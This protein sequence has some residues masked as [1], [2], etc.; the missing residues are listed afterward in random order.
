MA[1]DLFD[2][3]FM[4]QATEQLKDATTFL[5]NTFFKTQVT[6]E[7][8]FVDVDL[9]RGKRRISPYVQRRGEGPNVGKIAFVTDTF[10]P[11]YLKP[12]KVVTVDDLL[13][14]SR[15]QNIYG[16]QSGRAR[17]T[18][19]FGREMA[20][21][22]SMITRNEELQAS[23]ALFDGIVV[24]S[25]IDGNAVATIDYQRS[26]ANSETLS[27]ANRWDQSGSDPLADIRRWKRVIMQATG[28]MVDTGVLGADV[29]DALLANDEIK[30]YLD[31][32][33][34]HPW[35]EVP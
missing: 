20:D 29:V 7:T 12:K 27:G 2:T 28:H 4:L 3:R 15:G 6:F 21:L 8:R 1:I 9:F 5:I 11:P 18:E 10:E 14:R 16:S 23:Q 17:A 24:A 19:L 25:D 34:L 32:R 22:D 13:K 26:A 33:R 31:N 35:Q 30:A